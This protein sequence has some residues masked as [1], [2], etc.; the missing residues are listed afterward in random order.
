MA[1]TTKSTSSLS[2]ALSARVQDSLQVDHALSVALRHF[3]RLGAVRDGVREAYAEADT[4]RLH[5]DSNS[6]SWQSCSTPVVSIQA[7]APSEDG[8]VRL[9]VTWHV[10]VGGGSESRLEA[11]IDLVPLTSH[12]TAVYLEGRFRPPAAERSP[13][14]PS[15][16]DLQL[17]NV[18][19][20]AFLRHVARAI[21]AKTAADSQANASTPERRTKEGSRPT[22]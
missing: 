4:L 5:L 18:T 6:M 15:S 2:N 8:T 16:V 3:R 22:G 10:L 17:S 14:E 7:G 9:D 11:R 21:D 19:V 13:A 1:M 12:C 20:R